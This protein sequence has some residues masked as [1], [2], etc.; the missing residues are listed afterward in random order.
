M[1]PVN[2]TSYLPVDPCSFKG[3]NVSS[4]PI[5]QQLIKLLIAQFNGLY[6]FLLSDRHQ[7]HAMA[8]F[9]RRTSFK[10]TKRKLLSANRPKNLFPLFSNFCA[11]PNSYSHAIFFYR[12]NCNGVSH[13][14]RS[15]PVAISCGIFTFLTIE[16]HLQF[17]TQV[18]L[19]IKSSF[20]L[21]IYIFII[22]LQPLM[23]MADLI[24]LTL[25]SD[26]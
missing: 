12:F 10:D 22:V 9:T 26:L 6:L 18:E 17:F 13:C 4:S 20:K 24:Y 5:H 3:S 19:F 15:Y 2:V 21:Y 25:Q 14:N 23:Y 11:S 8:N 1:C 16:K 7:N